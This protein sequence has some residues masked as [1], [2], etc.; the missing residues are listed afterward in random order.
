MQCYS[1]GTKLEESHMQTVEQSLFT[2][3]K[4]KISKELQF[5]FSL[6]IN[7]FTHLTRVSFQKF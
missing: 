6:K 1:E 7:K 2:H 5:L 4:R 3:I